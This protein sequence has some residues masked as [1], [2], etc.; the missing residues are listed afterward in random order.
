MVGSK[1]EEA[2]IAKNG[3]KMVMA[4]A[5]AKVPK[6]TIIFGN[7]IGAGNYSMCGRAYDPRFLWIWPNAKISVIGET[8]ASEVM[9]SLNKHKIQDPKQQL[10]FQQKIINQYQTQSSPYYS[11]ARLWDDGIIDPIN[12]RMFIAYGLHIC[13]NRGEIEDTNFGIFRI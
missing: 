13:A 3:A 8:Q 12:T 9:L 4:V 1:S 6:L 5:N 10:E 7:S 11:T 2:G